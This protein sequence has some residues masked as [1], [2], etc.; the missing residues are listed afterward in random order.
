MKYEEMKDLINNIIE[1][2]FNH[3][4]EYRE[5]EF[6]N[7]DEEQLKLEKIS[8]NLL[9][10]LYKNIPK[11]CHGLLGGFDDAVTN[12]WLN[13]CMFYFKEGVR[14]GVANLNFLKSIE[15][16]ECHIN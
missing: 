13:L 4:Q 7:E 9:N 8:R 5:K 3:V 15:C 6:T 11:E 1:N 12:V 16:I 10:E 2:E 14:A